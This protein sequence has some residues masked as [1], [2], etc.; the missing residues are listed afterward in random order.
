MRT[1]LSYLWSLTVHCDDQVF[2]A[3][4]VTVKERTYHRK[5]ATCYTCNKPLSSKDLCDGKVSISPTF[6]EKIFVQ[7]NFA[8]LF[9][10]HTLA[11]KFFG[12]IILVQKLVVKCWWNWQ[13][14][15]I[16][17]T[18]YRLIFKQK[19]FAQLFSTYSLVM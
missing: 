10:T 15:S 4:K 12:K 11:L 14:V 5:C 9:F 19:Y 16:S 6:Y 7:M 8:R 13:K 18:L 1:T 2:H 3:E 17:L